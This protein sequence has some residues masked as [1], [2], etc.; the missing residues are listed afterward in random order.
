MRTP[1]STGSD[2]GEESWLDQA[3]NS[4]LITVHSCDETCSTTNRRLIEKLGGALA[5]GVRGKVDQASVPYTALGVWGE[6]E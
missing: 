1:T 3:L 4:G 6:M 2:N 5:S